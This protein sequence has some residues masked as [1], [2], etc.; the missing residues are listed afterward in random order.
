MTTLLNDLPTWLVAL[1][2]VGGCTALAVALL[3][4]LRDTIKASMREMHNE[5]AGYVFAAIA[6]LYALLLGFIIFAS[7]EHVG[8]AES[9]VRGEAASLTALYR[10]TVGLPGGMRQ[11][12]RTELRRYTNLVITVGWPALAHGAASPSID[13][14][15]DRLY[16]IYAPGSTAGVPAPVES[17]SLQLLDQITAARSARLADAHGF[18]TGAFWAVVIFGGVCTLAFA[19]LFYL[20]NAGIQVAMIALLAALISSMLFLL[21]ILD[22][23]FAG[24]YSVSPEPFRI[25][26]EQMRVAH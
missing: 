21:V 20:E 8:A 24:G 3:L 2:V 5:V 11:Q 18:L 25:A 26:L 22:H 6:V 1:I 7:W 16:Q 15:L 4:L 17:E 14:S 10:G 12:A 19:L 23:P 13:A 9:D